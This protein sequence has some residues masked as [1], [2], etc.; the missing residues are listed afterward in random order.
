MR[1]CE[2]VVEGRAERRTTPDGQTFVV[3]RNPNAAEYENLYVRAPYEELKGW[4]SP[5]DREL[6][7]W[8]A[9]YAHHTDIQ[10][11][12]PGWRA[13]AL[14]KDGVASDEFDGVS[15]LLNS[16]LIRRL[17]R[18]PFWV[19][20]R[21]AAFGMVGSFWGRILVDPGSGAI[22]KKEVFTERAEAPLLRI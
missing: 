14:D 9:Y 21:G 6:L 3:L 20:G 1:I 2:I 4:L 16:K 18:Q 11:P 22:L 12:Q 8:G 10:E 13:I 19:I 5:D 15:V 17:F 7:V